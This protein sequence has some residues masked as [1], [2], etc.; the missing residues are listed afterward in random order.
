MSTEEYI[1]CPNCNARYIIP[2]SDQLL[3]I[4]CTNCNKVFYKYPPKPP[5]K[6]FNKYV[7]LGII[8]IAVLAFVFFY[9]DSINQGYKSAKSMFSG[10]KPNNWITIAYGGLVNKSTLTHSGETVGEII[11]KIPNYTDD[12]KGLVQQ[13]LE[14]YSILCH[15]VLLTTIEPD[16]LPFIN[17]IAH[18]PLGS[19]Q[20]AWVE[21]F[22][23]GHFQ[24]YYN[25]YT[26]RVF[27]KGSDP[28]ISFNEY[29]SVIR[30]PIQDILKSKNTSIDR[31]E[32]YVFNN[33]YATTEI[34]LNT[35]PKVCL[36]EELDLSSKEK[37][38]DLTSIDDFLKQSVKLEAIEVN[39]NNDLILYGKEAPKQT[40]AG[41]P[42]SLAD[43]AVIY[44]SI[45][46]HGN[47]APYVSLDK[48]EDNRYAKI[49]FGGHLENTHVGHVVLEA[50]KL[51]KALST[52]FDPNTHK[53]IISEIT[54]HVPSF[55]TEDERR[56]LDDI[57]EG[58]IQIRYWFYPDSIGTVTDGSI[59]AVLSHQFL[60]DV[61]RMDIKVDVDNAVR[62]TIDHLNQNFS[63]YERADRTFQELNTIGRIMALINW[64]MGMNMD[65]RIA[66]DDLLSVNIPAFTTPKQTKKMLA[67]TA[68]AYPDGFDLNSRNV[69]DYTKEY[70]ISHIL[71]QHS[72][73]TSDKYFLQMAGSYFSQFDIS[74]L[75]PQTFNDL[76]SS[77]EYYDRLIK[78]NKTEIEMLENVINQKKYSLDRYE[79]RE[80]KQYNELVDR[81]N[82]LVTNQKSYIDIYNSKIKEINNMNIQSRYN[83]SIGGGINLR[84]KEFKKISRNSNSPL[85]Q[86]IAKI[87][88]KIKTVGKIG[89]SENWI[90]SNPKTG[91]SRI[92]VL[93]VNSW[94][95]SKSV[96]GKIEYKLRSN[97][98]D[99]L[100]ISLS[101]NMEEWQLFTSLN[102]SQDIVKYSKETN[103]IQVNH[104]SFVD[105]CSGK[106]SPNGKKV[107]FYR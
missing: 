93:P 61:E 3:K 98:G 48:H 27:L 29:Q 47:N 71:D 9:Q 80:V 82:N 11:R 60:A 36:L 40:L 73:S 103:R 77:I 21:L 35:I 51:F 83:A 32:I 88:S 91:G 24:L 22:R 8:I 38:I 46:H 105:E 62:E 102:G 26:I 41:F 95:S 70:Y 23:E 33:E 6:Q 45:Y 31:F 78:A 7:I 100:S 1:K 30:H 25:N 5:K 53:I 57:R 86:E 50:D 99:I 90:R 92:N 96:N 20:P 37:S 74:K 69:R 49:N 10:P 68:I 28:D 54:K 18:Y 39:E 106:I 14:P 107:E 13:Y 97:S 79:S 52:G 42:L 67:I 34:R 101:Q 15:D 65:E 44:R 58:H 104:S 17:I 89:K 81:Y 16:T 63:Q 85:I 19:Y 84:P 4:T 72:P 56:L 76:Q 59:G 94:S 64:L 66:L 12:I 55:L 43:I 2:R 87:K 75:A